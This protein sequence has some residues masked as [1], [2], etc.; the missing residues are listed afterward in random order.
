VGTKYLLPIPSVPEHLSPPGLYRFLEAL[1]RG[2]EMLA[3]LLV[4]PDSSSVTY[5]TQAD[6]TNQVYDRSGCLVLVE[7]DQVNIAVGSDVPVQ[8]TQEE[9]DFQSDFNIS[10]YAF[11]APITGVYL[12]TVTVLLENLDTAASLYE[13]K[14]V[15]TNETYMISLDPS[16]MTGDFG[17]VPLVFNRP[18]ILDLN[19]TLEVMVRQTGGA[20]QT[21]IKAGSW[22]SCSFHTG[23][24]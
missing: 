24:E 15:T 1:K 12:V 5:A 2:Y 16:H 13:L 21:T 11:T 23:T 22:L 10:T 18:V 3:G 7:T 20:A 14:V 17:P 19:D 4:G 6:L 9:W 8:F